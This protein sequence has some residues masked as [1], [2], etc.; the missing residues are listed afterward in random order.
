MCPL[1]MTF[2]WDVCILFIWHFTET[3]VLLFI[4]HFTETYVPSSY[5]IYWDIWHLLRR[6]YPLHMTFYILLRRMFPLH[7]TFYW[8]V[9]A[10]FIWHFTE[11]YVS[12]SYDIYWDVCILFIWHFTETYVP[13]LHMTFTETYVSSSYDILL[14]RMCPL[15]ITFTKTYVPSS[16]NIYWDVCTLFIFYWDI[17]LRPSSYVRPSS[18]NILLRRMYPLHM[19]F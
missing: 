17:L 13:P 19:T 5:D 11:T 1:H 8:D 3:Y 7:I 15:H 12:S 6:M 18:Y 10:L 4:W 9:C 2:Y 14:R 16:Y